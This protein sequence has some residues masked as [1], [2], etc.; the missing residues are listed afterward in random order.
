MATNKTLTEFKTALSGGGAR[1]NLFEVAITLPL[2][3]NTAVGT[4]DSKF[5]LYVRQQI[6]Q[7]Q[8]LHLS[9]FLFVEELLKLL[10]TELMIHGRSQSLTILIL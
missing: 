3:A 5:T 2:N 6:F 7:H 9:M 4:L 1:P 10:E 8:I